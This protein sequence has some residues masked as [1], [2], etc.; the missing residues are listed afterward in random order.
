MNPKKRVKCV[1]YISPLRK[2]YILCT[3][4]AESCQ[5]VD[6][7]AR[8]MWTSGFLSPVDYWH[9]FKVTDLGEEGGWGWGW[10]P[11]KLTVQPE[12]SQGE[13]GPNNRL[14]SL[15]I[16][17]DPLM[18]GALA[19]QHEWW[20]KVFVLGV[21]NRHAVA[22]LFFQLIFNFFSEFVFD[23]WPKKMSNFSKLVHVTFF[24]RISN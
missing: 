5:C 4:S 23:N 22:K 13:S 10:H 1:L 14:K 21:C 16:Q 6:R 17:S 19:A 2:Q 24:C 3:A 18:T 15:R 20:I 8:Q 9:F 7:S 12:V 11:L